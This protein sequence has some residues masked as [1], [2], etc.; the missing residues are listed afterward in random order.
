MVVF[1]QNARRDV[2]EYAK[3]ILV[4]LPVN[5]SDGPSKEKRKTALERRGIFRKC[6]TENVEHQSDSQ[7]TKR[8]S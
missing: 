2:S 1:Q 4:R 8:V 3:Q 6:C 7:P 5:N